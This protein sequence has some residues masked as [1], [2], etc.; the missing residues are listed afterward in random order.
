MNHSP[1]TH[2]RTFDIECT[3]RRDKISIIQKLEE[4]RRTPR[5][6]EEHKLPFRSKKKDER[7]APD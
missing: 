3:A 1:S 5:S 6:L 2:I 7:I 4:E